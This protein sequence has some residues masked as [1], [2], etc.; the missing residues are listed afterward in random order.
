MKSWTTRMRFGGTIGRHS[1]GGSDGHD[2][3]TQ[4]SEDDQGRICSQIG[5]EEGNVE[6]SHAGEGAKGRRDTQDAVDQGQHDL[7]V[8]IASNGSDDDR[9]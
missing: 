3:K 4:H 5:R 6:G 9:R 7:R 2:Q 1:R 8:L